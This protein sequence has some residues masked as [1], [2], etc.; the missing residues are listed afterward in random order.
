[1]LG[2]RILNAC[3]RLCTIIKVIEATDAHIRFHLLQSIQLDYGP[4]LNR[5]GL[6]GFFAW[7]ELATAAS[8]RPFHQKTESAESNS[9][10]KKNAVS[11][12]HECFS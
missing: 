4:M 1:L 7:G 6:C 5:S 9:K 2:Y 12:D 3:K 8:P 11:V 10:D